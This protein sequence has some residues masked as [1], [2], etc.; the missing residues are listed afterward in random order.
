MDF[1]LLSVL[2]EKGRRIA[3]TAFP[4]CSVCL[5][6]NFIHFRPGIDVNSLGHSV[7]GLVL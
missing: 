2:C 5:S 7:D 4:P 1:A 6:H 3:F